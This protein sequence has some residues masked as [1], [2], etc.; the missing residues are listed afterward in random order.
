MHFP[1]SKKYHNTSLSE[2]LEHLGRYYIA[3]V[4]GMVESQHL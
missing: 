2:G 4:Y 3:L 1:V